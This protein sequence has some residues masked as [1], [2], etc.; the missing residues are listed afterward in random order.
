MPFQAVTRIPREV[1]KP[2]PGIPRTAPIASIGRGQPGE[3]QVARFVLAGRPRPR[4]EE[5]LRI[6]A[7]ARW[8]LIR[9]KGGTETPAELLGRDANGP[10]RDDPEHAHAFYLPEDADRDGLGAI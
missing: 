7:I 2:L 8:A 1:N 6:A 9:R 5:T 10:L 4:I 3:P